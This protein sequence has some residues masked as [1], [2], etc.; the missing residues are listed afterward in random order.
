MTPTEADKAAAK[1]IAHFMPGLGWPKQTGGIASTIAR[2]MAPERAAT[3]ALREELEGAKGRI[4]WLEKCFRE[5]QEELFHGRGLGP[6]P[7]DDAR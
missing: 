7:K 5:A 2:H 6:L 3:A 4:A 1:E